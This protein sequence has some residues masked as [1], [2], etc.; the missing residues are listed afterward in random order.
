MTVVLV[1]REHTGRLRWCFTRQT[2]THRL[3]AYREP[4]YYGP[5]W[6]YSCDHCGRDG[7]FFPG[8][9]PDGIAGWCDDESIAVAA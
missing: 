4:S 1:L 7:R 5:W 6:E 3:L 8:L 2:G 9:Q